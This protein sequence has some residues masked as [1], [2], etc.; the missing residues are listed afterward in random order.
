M[1]TYLCAPF[2]ALQQ[3]TLALVL[4]S[5]AFQAAAEPVRL[6]LRDADISALIATVAQ[7]TG[8]NFIIDPRVKGKVTVVS[9]NPMEPDELYDVF[10]SILQVHGL[11][12]IQVDN[13]IKIV[14]DVKARQEGT[15]SDLSSLTGDEIVTRV[16]PITNVQAAQLVPVLRPL[17]P[18]EG[19]LAAAP[20]TNALVISDRAANVR[21]L[22]R[23][24]QQIDQASDAEVEVISLK[25]AAAGEVVRVLTALSK[26]APQQGAQRTPTVI[27]DERT[28]SVLIGGEPGDRLR[29]RALIAHLDTPTESSGR[30]QVVYLHYAK[31]ED[32]VKVLTG[33]AEQTVDPKQ[34]KTPTQ[35]AD[36]SIQA[37]VSSNALV[38]TAPPDVFRSLQEVIRQLDIRRA[39]VMVEAIIAEISLDKARELGVQWAIDGSE[40]GNSGVLSGT[41]FSAGNSS[42]IDIAGAVSEGNIPNIGDGLGLAIGRLGS[43][44]INYGLLLR[45]LANDAST[46][47]LSTPSLMTL[48]NQEAEIV[49][50]QN[51]PFVTGQFT[52]TGAAAGSVNPFQTIQ[53]QDI[54]L[55]LRVTPQ[56]NEG[57]AVQLE[58]EQEVSS[59]A[60]SA[61]TAADII[62]NKRSIKTTVMVEDGAVIVLG[63]LIDDTLQVTNQKVPGLGDIPL[64][65]RLFRYDKTQ[66]VKRDLVVFLRPTIVRDD[67]LQARLTGSKY[68]YIRA[69]QLQR[70]EKGVDLMPDEEQPVLPELDID[71]NRGDGDKDSAV[72]P[73]A[74]GLNDTGD[75]ITFY[76]GDCVCDEETPAEF[77]RS[78][79]GN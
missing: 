9:P 48:D 44:A 18:Q 40:G 64:L 56:I 47:I 11:A 1:S 43:S 28:N 16:I 75:E 22:A 27:A 37:D 61:A 30:T 77:N 67:A 53:R 14:P 58:V 68:S 50:G 55:T 25:H 23:I 74:G 34:A 79:A 65:G 59:I 41:N 66:K 13:V 26:D 42:L 51:V 2:R 38:I 29:M 76:E 19:H 39:Q 33:I 72:A 60:Q 63:G 12:A 54:G 4:C 17:V 45:A 5:S 20:A 78:V 21:R 8:K 10:L 35:G 31:A 69:R 36:V 57:N 7:Q 70:Q 6:D 49:V 24:I 71:T 3:V 73:G 46:N 52:N 62:T 15:T 32:L